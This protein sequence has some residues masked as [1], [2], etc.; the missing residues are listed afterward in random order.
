MTEEGAPV[1]EGNQPAAAAQGTDATTGYDYRKIHSYPLIKVSYVDTKNF[2]A[3]IY[4]MTTKFIIPSL[5]T[6]EMLR[7]RCGTDVKIFSRF[8]SIG[9][10]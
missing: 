7:V 10:G 6:Y 1:A 3:E 2:Y 4:K 9:L 8:F 5:R